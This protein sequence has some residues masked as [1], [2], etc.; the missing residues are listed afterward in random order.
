M[1]REEF[2]KQLGRNPELSDGA[3]ELVT[4][5]YNFHPTIPDVGGKKVIA[6]LF[7]IGGMGI[8]RDMVAAADTAKLC[9]NAIDAAKEEV[10]VAQEKLRAAQKAYREF[11]SGYKTQG[12][13]EED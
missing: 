11:K 8:I 7:N 2:V 3:W 5:V 13:D 4:L 10:R 9:E 6:D 12:P 1:T